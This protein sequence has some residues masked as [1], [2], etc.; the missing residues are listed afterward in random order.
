MSK[1]AYH[2]HRYEGFLL[3]RGE[4]LIVLIML[5]KSIQY[6]FCCG[7]SAFNKWFPIKG[8]G[9]FSTRALGKAPCGGIPPLA[10]LVSVIIENVLELPVKKLSKLGL[11]FLI[12]KC[13][14]ISV[15]VCC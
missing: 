2:C 7:E 9:G 11:I 6:C 14:G 13:G 1:G 5:N 8:A 12:S 3:R 4:L 10:F 15:S